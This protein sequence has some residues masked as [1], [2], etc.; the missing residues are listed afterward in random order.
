LK[1]LNDSNEDI[2]R[3][4]RN[5]NVRREIKDL[6][7]AHICSS[8]CSHGHQSLWPLA[9]QYYLQTSTT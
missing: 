9:F 4:A 8:Y 3:L 5:S 1:P 7:W 6:Y 2:N